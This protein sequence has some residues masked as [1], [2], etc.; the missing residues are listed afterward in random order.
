MIRNIYSAGPISSPPAAGLDQFA[1][2]RENRLISSIIA[3]PDS[4]EVPRTA[5]HYAFAYDART[6]RVRRSQAC[7]PSVILSFAGGLSVQEYFTKESGRPAPT[8]SSSDSSSASSNSPASNSDSSSDSSSSHSQSD[9]DTLPGPDV[10][11]IRGS[12]YGGGIGGILYSIRKTTVDGQSVRLASLDHYNARGD[13]IAKSTA[14]AASD[15]TWMA[16]YLAF[17]TRPQEKGTN[18]DPHRANTKEEDGTG[19]AERRASLPLPR[20]RHVP[21]PRPSRLRGRAESVCV[22]L[23]CHLRFGV[24]VMPSGSTFSLNPQMTA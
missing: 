5:G 4:A 13:V 17:G 7:K 20:N 9:P 3:A 10:E 11:Y 15:V 8:S 19:F 24:L 22:A 12:D 14:D 23:P 18:P 1:Y 2:D 16:A 21:N 6:R